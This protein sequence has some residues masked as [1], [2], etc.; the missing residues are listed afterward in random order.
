MT[1]LAIA[2][3]TLIA[4]GALFALVGAIGML[5]LPDFYTRTHAAGITDSAGVGLLLLGLLLQAESFAVA[6]R[7]LLILLFLLFTGPTTVHALAH[8]AYQDGLKPKLGKPGAD[9]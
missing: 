5:R 1:A 2:S 4:A 6:I 7:I 3:W 9:A 8:A